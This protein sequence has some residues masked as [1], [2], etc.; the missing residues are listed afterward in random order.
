M[1][2]SDI[3]L[4]YL[5]GYPLYQRKLPS[6]WMVEEVGFDAFYLEHSVFFSLDACYNSDKS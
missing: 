2:N 4:V 6:I 5:K 1:Y 3:V